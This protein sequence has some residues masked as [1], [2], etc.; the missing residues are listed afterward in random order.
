[1]LMWEKLLSKMDFH[2]FRRI[3]TDHQSV[4]CDSSLDPN[5]GLR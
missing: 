2:N 1:M 5:S 4:Y 3:K